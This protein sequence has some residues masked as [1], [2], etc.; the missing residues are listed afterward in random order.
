MEESP[1]FKRGYCCMATRTLTILLADLVG[2]TRQVTKIDTKR[3]AEFIEDATRPI[4]NAVQEANGMVIKFTGDGFLA[5]FESARDALI[6]ADAIRDHYIRQRQTPGGYV[7]DG[8]RVV[9]NTADVVCEDD[10][11]VGDGV[12][13]C[14][15]LEK[16]VPTNQ[17]WLTAATREV[18]GISDFVF[19]PVGDIQLRGRPQ[20]VMVYSLENTEQS[21]IEYG[22]ILVVTDLH[23]YIEVGEALSP[24]ALNE[25]LAKWANLHRESTVGLRGQVRQFVADMAL[26]SFSD[27]DDA[28]QAVLNLRALADMHNRQHPD[29]LDYHFKATMATGDLM[30]SPTGVVGRLVNKTFD[31]LNATPRSAVSMDADTYAR[32]RDYRD[33]MEPTTLKAGRDGSEI[34]SY[35]LRDES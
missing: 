18:V 35:L 3:A 17:V 1:L 29:L 31:L 28:V 22:T 12:I 23:H 30:L 33:R 15:R 5:T 34:A 20:P 27:A 10:D 11:V 14:A 26:M 6:C 13:V 19:H 16:S 4:K 7:V 21:F 9:V 2:S 24:V 25:W 8:I 32:L